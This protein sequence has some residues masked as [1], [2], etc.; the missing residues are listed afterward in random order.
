MSSLARTL[1]LSLLATCV[2]TAC[3][4][5]ATPTTDAGATTPAAGSSTPPTHAPSALARIADELNPLASP[6]DAIKASMHKFLGLRSYHATMTFEGG[7]GTAMGHHEIDFVAPDRYRMQMPMGTQI[8]I[9]DTMYM[10]MRGRT[11]KMPMPAGMLSQWRDPAKLAESEAGM[12]VQAQ[13]NDT[14]DGAPARKYLVHHQQPQPTDVT[15]WI[16]R[17]GLPVRIQVGSL[18]QG[19]QV[20]ST[21]DYSRFDDP[22]IAIDP[23]IDPPIAPPR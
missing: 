20:T 6:K 13:G 17:D 5:A 19:K 12:T 8:I 21:I 4:P 18:V 22:A 7:P 15:M 23:P 10:Q 3:K 11:T 16:N 9:G 1:A 14:I 2:L